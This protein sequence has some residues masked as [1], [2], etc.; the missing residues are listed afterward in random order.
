MLKTCLRCGVEKDESQF[1]KERKTKCGLKSD[2]KSC[3]IDIEKNRQLIK[4]NEINAK[5]ASFR[6]ANREL[7]RQQ[8]KT[9][10]E[11]NKNRI[12][13]Q[14]RKK[15]KMPK[16]KIAKSISD[17]KYYEKHKDE[18]NSK[19]KGYV[20]KRYNKDLCFRLTVILRS[21]LHKIISGKMKKGSAV[22]DLGC[23]I[24]YLLTY[25]ESKFQPGMNWQNWSKYGWHI[26]HIIPLVTIKTAADK[27]D[28][29][30]IVCHYTNLQPLWAEENLKKS[31]KIIN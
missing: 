22:Q 31:N 10:Y 12:N 14:S 7:I 29:I 26:D 4:R 11:K 27:E 23:S 1:H 25:L 13:A 18:I 24:S 2:C 17:K 9:W 20:K 28:Q 8:K 15:Q 6:E 16:Y 3:R 21:R 5:R 19:R 30:K